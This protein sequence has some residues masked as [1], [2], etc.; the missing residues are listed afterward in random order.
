MIK[1]A[2]NDVT[3]VTFNKLNCYP[4]IKHGFSTRLGGV[5]TGVFESMNLGFNRG[6]DDENV[7]EN[8]RRFSQAIG[9]DY[10]RL[11]FS[12]QT[13]TTN[14]RVVTEA[15]AGNGIHKPLPYHDV[16]GIVT[17]VKNL[18]LVT[19][20]ADCVPLF[21]YDPVEQVIALSHSGW[22]GTVGRIGKLTVEKMETEFGSKP[23]NIIACIGPSICR[24]CYEVSQDVADEFRK[25]YG[26]D[27][28]RLIRKS[29]F[30]PDDDSK[31]ML[32]LWE[33]CRLNFIEAGVLPEN[34][35]VTE[36]CTRCECDRFF[37]HRIMGVKR[38]SLAA[39]LSL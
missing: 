12:H 24:D 6:D 4:E 2:N 7:R 9:I 11:C 25:S 5:S 27:A 21:L 31:Y 15:D 33:A 23:A 39:F 38:G 18:P 36:H 19:F 13:H 30:N 10:N 14:I 35:E 29:V 16:D 20:Y 28:N 34:I 17:N 32:D 37:S 8:F 26:Q 3:Y 1:I 22:R